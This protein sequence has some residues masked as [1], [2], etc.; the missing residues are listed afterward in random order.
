MVP[1]EQPFREEEE[2]TDLGSGNLPIPPLSEFPPHL[3]REASDYAFGLVL[4]GWTAEDAEVEGR[5]MVIVEMGV[6]VD[7]SPLSIQPHS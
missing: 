3:Q 1:L 6:T 7:I 2:T 5:C 4:G